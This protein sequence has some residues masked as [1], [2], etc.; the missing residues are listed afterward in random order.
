VDRVPR[1]RGR[2]TILSVS[3]VMT[4]EEIIE[5]YDS[6]GASPYKIDT[7]NFTLETHYGAWEAQVPLKFKAPSQKRHTFAAPVTPYFHGRFRKKIR[8]TS[9]CKA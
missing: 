1:L 6:V 3:K 2:A 7:A 9:P 4:Y 8:R 5:R